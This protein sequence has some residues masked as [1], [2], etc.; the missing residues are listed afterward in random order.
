MYQ[1]FLVKS[2]SWNVH[3]TPLQ[4]HVLIVI[5]LSD[6]INHIQ[7][8][9]LMQTPLMQ[10]DWP[11]SVHNMLQGNPFNEGLRMDRMDNEERKCY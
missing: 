3:E 6:P 9:P 1:R 7:K 5:G 11:K 2:I 10:S 4:L 8:H